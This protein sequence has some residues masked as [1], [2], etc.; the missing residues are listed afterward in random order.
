MSPIRTTALLLFPTLV[1]VPFLAGAA[2]SAPAEVPPEKARFFEARVRPI[3]LDHCVQCHQGDRPAGGLRLDSAAGLRRGGARGAVVAP[4]KPEESTLVR[5]IR[6]EDPKLKMPPARRLSPAQLADLT[7]WVRQGAV[8]PESAAR[9]A[10]DPKAHWAFQPVRRPTAPAV[11]NR[12][13]VRN[14]IDQF[15]LARLEARG[16][17]PNPPALPRELI[18]RVSYNLT[19]LPPSPADVR[20][21]EKE[22]SDRGYPGLVDRLLA[23]P[24]YGEHWARRWLDLVRFAETNSY[25]RDNPKP[26]AWRYRDYVIRA[27][28]D[29]RPFDR[30]LREQIAGDEYPDSGDEGR[31]ATAFYRLGIWDDEP[32]EREQARY[33]GLDDIIT[34]TGQVVLGLTLDCARCHDH[35]IDPIPQKDYYRFLAFFQN[36]NH[37]RNGGPTD[38]LV[39]FGT[40]ADRKRYAEAEARLNDQRSATDRQLALLEKEYWA[41]SGRPGAPPTGDELRRQVVLDGP[42]VL[43][44]ETFGKYQGLLRE[45][46]RLAR[47]QV[48]A[49]RALCVTEA[50]ARAPETFVLL[51]GS[52]QAPGDKVEPGFPAIFGGA[53]AVLRT[54]DAGARTAGRRKV[55]AEWL[56]SSENRLTGRVIV[57]RVWQQ[58]FG[59]GIVRSPNNFGLQGDAPTHPEL[60]DWL[61]ATFVAPEAEGGCGWSL[62]RLQRLILDS[63]TF[64]QSSRGNAAALAA[65]PA[66]D[67]FWR[68]DMRRLSAEE[69]RDSILSASGALNLKMFGPG[70]YPE[71]PAEVLAGQSRP[72]YGWGKSTPEEQSR[73]SVYIHVKR[74]L[75]LPFL[76]TFDAAE[77][78]RTTPLRFASTQPLQA[79]TMLNGAFIQAQSQRMA[80]RLEREAG[81]DLE[82]Q[83][84]LAL[85]LVLGH[86]PSRS[87]VER[88]LRLIGALRR[89]HGVDLPAAR[90]RF[91]LM[92][93]SLNEFVYLD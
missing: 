86:G 6:Y 89:Q 27:F 70:I 83:V 13:W 47:E 84:D 53:P 62:K 66:N 79:L 37:F 14:P 60:L 43:G 16:L 3:L 67:L 93:L 26:N 15:I 71:I 73:R 42:K 52:A 77:T 80:E 9:R 36:I 81:P 64:R 25:E 61:A 31:I 38:E 4:G 65:D 58:M 41:K 92:A 34:T 74:S 39:L 10:A 68:V 44:S 75:L 90:N 23:S 49:E 22:T 21:F 72:G 69:L 24:R 35:K 87:Q 40:D 76:E 5:A 85:E 32:V 2:R 50:G 48:P 91:C 56:A 51:R 18:R 55:L 45:K 1:L 19:G 20:A 59:R 88:G 29:D 54:P 17:S 8:F 82:R 11:R 12:A 63:N 7:E 78:D 28:N 33:D 30:F 46:D 57:N